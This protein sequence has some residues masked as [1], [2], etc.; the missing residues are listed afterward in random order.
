MAVDDLPMPVVNFLN[1]IGV[2]WPYVD[3]DAVLRFAKVVREFAQAVENTHREATD[4]VS[5]IAEAHQ[6]SST[7]VMNSGWSR[8][9]AGHVHE[10]VDA[11]HVVA[12]A[13][14]AAA[15]YIVAQKLEAI[16]ILVGMAAAF[17]ADQAAAVA[18]AGLAEAAVPLI[19]EGAERVVK[20]L[21]MDLEQHVIG[22]VVEAGAKPL[23]AKVEA[24]MSG[25]DWGNAGGDAPTGGHGFSVDPAA[26]R[27]HTAA[28]RDQAA[29][30]RS[31]GDAFQAAVAGLGF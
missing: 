15:G 19:V 1:V 5:R 29:T 10:L 8:M 21:V 25:L 13:L 27:G 6:G 2:P 9:S 14:D 18:T 24:A 7:E 28:L 20:S 12:D 16:G 23:F 22:K 3:E 11:C 17:V 26:V 4:T 30:M 31:H